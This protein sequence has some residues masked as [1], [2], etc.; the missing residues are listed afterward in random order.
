[1]PSPR[2][3]LG[4]LA[5]A[6]LLVAGCGSSGD[7]AKP[8]AAAA[9]AA[10]PKPAAAMPA[11][12]AARPTRAAYTRSADK[13][14]RAARRI[15]VEANTAVQRAYAAKQST[16][17]ADA[18]EHYGPLYAEKIKEL[19]ALPRPVARA[20]VLTAFMKVLDAQVTALTG[21]ATAMRTADSAALKQLSEFQVQTKQY[22]ETLGKQYGFT[23]CGRAA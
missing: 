20:K 1:M 5:V 3:L 21:T 13:V 6:A 22:A 16:A 8:A 12:T 11:A 19:Q 10:T 14:C 4:V 9:K 23:V 7:D 17:A 18:I 15:S 2:P